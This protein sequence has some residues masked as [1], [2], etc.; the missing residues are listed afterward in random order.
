MCAKDGRIDFVTTKCE[1]KSTEYQIAKNNQINLCSSGLANGQ[2][3]MAAI[4]RKMNNRSKIAY[5][6][7]YGNGTPKGT[8]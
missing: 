1:H 4:Q 6:L 5:A 3:E 2:K 7:K 8:N